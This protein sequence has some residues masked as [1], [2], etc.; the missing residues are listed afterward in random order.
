VTGA[1]PSNEKRPTLKLLLYGLLFKALKSV[2]AHARTAGQREEKTIMRS[3]KLLLSVVLLMALAAPAWAVTVPTISPGW[4]FLHARD[5][6]NGTAYFADGTAPVTLPITFNPQTGL[7][8][9]VSNIPAPGAIGSEDSWGI[10]LMYSIAPGAPAEGNTKVGAV[11]PSNNTY[12]NNPRFPS[13]RQACNLSCGLLM[14]VVLAL[15]P[16]I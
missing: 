4:N 9:G 13:S 2:L 11:F 7:P 12:S 10:V 1:K 14:R 5:Q 8:A 3:M 6:D 15:M 16:T